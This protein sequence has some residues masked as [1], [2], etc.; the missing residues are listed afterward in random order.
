MERNYYSV[1]RGSS[2][3]GDMPFVQTFDITNGKKNILWRSQSPYYETVVDVIDGKNGTFLTSRESPTETPNYY[4]ITQII[5][6]Y[7]NYFLINFCNAIS[8]KFF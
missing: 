5:A 3:D 6:N 8:C 1:P 4:T 2:P 7:T